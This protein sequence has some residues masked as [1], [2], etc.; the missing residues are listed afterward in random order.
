MKTIEIEIAL[1]KHFGIRQNIIV[2]NINWGLWIHE[3]DLFIVRPSGNT[4]EIEIKVSFAD[5]KKDFTK[6]HNHI[7]KFNRIHK[8]YYAMP[9]GLIDKCK[10]MIPINSGLIAI[11][12]DGKCVV[13]KEAVVNNGFIKL[14]E[15]EKYQVCR[16]GA[17]RIL[18]LKEKINKLNNK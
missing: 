7:D 8:F 15:K 10:Q 14:T 11:E 2:P 4:I 17:M 5:F 18:T 1:M 12:E 6:K 3:C 13:M 9:I 16:L